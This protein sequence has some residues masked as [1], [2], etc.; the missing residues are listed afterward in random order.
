MDV[1]IDEDAVETAEEQADEIGVNDIDDETPE[2]SDNDDD[3]IMVKMWITVY[4]EYLCPQRSTARRLFLC[5]LDK[6]E[7]IPWNVRLLTRHN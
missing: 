1:N 3:D 7:V 5:Q 6:P 2:A 4:P